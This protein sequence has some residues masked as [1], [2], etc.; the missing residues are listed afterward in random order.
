[1]TLFLRARGAL[2]PML[3]AV[4]LLVCT[5]LA[6]QT[7]DFKNG[8]YMVKDGGYTLDVSHEGAAMRVKEPNKVS[9]Y[10][11]V[12]PGTYQFYSEKTQT[13]Y[14]MRVVNDH[15]LIAFKPDRPDVPG[16]ELVLI[17][18][19]PGESG[20]AVSDEVTGRYEAL[21]EQYRQKSES[22]PAN[23]QAWTA[24]S[25]VALKRSVS[26]AA[27]A[28]AFSSQMAGMLKQM[29]VDTNTSPCPDVIPQW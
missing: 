8:T 15:T 14:G 11:L 21:A 3:A 20:L 4:S 27:E 29:L 1:M 24:C 6:A 23:A 28:D 13:N 26:N 2:L 19:A 18:S 25:A 10:A 7:T 17:N 5:P 16:T 22:D 9:D 12:S